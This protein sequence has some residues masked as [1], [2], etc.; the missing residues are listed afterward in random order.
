M[1]LIKL[2]KDMGDFSYE[3]Q[4]IEIKYKPN[5]W[6]FDLVNAGAIKE[7][8]FKEQKSKVAIVDCT[9]YPARR[10]FNAFFDWGP[11]ETHGYPIA[12]L[13]KGLL[14]QCQVEVYGAA[15]GADIAQAIEDAISRGFEVINI[16]MRRPSVAEEQKQEKEFHLSQMVR[17]AVGGK[18][19][20]SNF[21]EAVSGYRKAQTELNRA[22]IGLPLLDR[23]V[24]RAKKKGVV[25]VA[26]SGYPFSESRRRIEDTFGYY[27][28]VFV[29]GSIGKD[30]KP[31]ES[32]P[33]SRVDIWAPAEGLSL[34]AGGKYETFGFGHSFA[35]PWVAVACALVK[36]LAGREGVDVKK[37]VIES[38]KKV[39]D[40]RIVNYGF[41][42]KRLGGEM[43]H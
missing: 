19:T 2:K 1:I 11:G 4:P 35:A 8:N 10:P 43:Q 42:L 41:L 6:A 17:Q 31:T 34:P 21:A 37:I 18:Q 32:S 14:P 38:A 25:I 24:A 12:A 9:P 5:Q 26:A 40:I 23:A 33:E 30:L 29:A 13:I 27:P 22:I 28:E 7:A 36:S 3:L 15:S 39:G 20:G 16:S